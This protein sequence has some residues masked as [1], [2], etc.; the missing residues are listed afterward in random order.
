MHYDAMICT[1]SNV[2]THC[3]ITMEVLSNIITHCDFTMGIPS[4]MIT[5]CD[6]IT[7]G[8]CDVILIDL[9]WPDWSPFREHI[10]VYHIIEW[11]NMTSQSIQ[12]NK[13][14]AVMLQYISAVFTFETILSLMCNW[15][16]RRTK[17]HNLPG[18]FYP[19][20]IIIQNSIR[21][22]P[23]HKEI[24]ISCNLKLSCGMCNNNHYHKRL[25][26]NGCWHTI[27][28]FGAYRYIVIKSPLFV[29]PSHIKT[30]EIYFINSIVFHSG[31]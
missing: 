13:S 19:L 10:P 30:G 23:M 1:Q 16:I 12:Y 21:T 22:K 7:S 8:H 5:H 11:N 27:H 3:D 15:Y 6:A 26:H 4:N 14:F 31:Y 20:P 28:A 25:H 9:H 2:I 17:E 29:I 18:K 24:S